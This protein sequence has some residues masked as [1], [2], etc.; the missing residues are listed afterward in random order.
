MKHTILLLI[1][2]SSLGLSAATIKMDLFEKTEVLQEQFSD[3][4]QMIALD[5]RK[6]LSE[7]ANYD[8]AAQFRMI[9]LLVQ[10]KALDQELVNM[11][12]NRPSALSER[13]KKEKDPVL[14]KKQ[15]LV[16][17]MVSGIQQI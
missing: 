14:R 3:R 8:S 15:S 9:D 17:F 13:I 2:L 1:L 6:Q 16:L 12:K 5:I 4:N 7:I 11:A 10:R